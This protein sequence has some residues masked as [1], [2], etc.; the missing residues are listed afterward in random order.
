MTESP[1]DGRPRWEIATLIGI[2]ALAGWLRL[3]QLE[4][5]EFKIDEA[6]AVD[7]G[8][9]VLD[10]EFVTAGLVSSIGAENPPS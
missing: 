10:G 5:A 9:R 4:L 1:N 7:L 6:T 8:R 3:R 2:G